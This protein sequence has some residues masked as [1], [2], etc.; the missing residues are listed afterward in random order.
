MSSTPESVFQQIHS[1]LESAAYLMQYSLSEHPHSPE[2][3][4]LMRSALARIKDAEE[5]ARVAIGVPAS[6]LAPAEQQKSGQLPASSAPEP[7]SFGMSM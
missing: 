5:T 3:R 7:S 6:V 4:L 1:H 2:T